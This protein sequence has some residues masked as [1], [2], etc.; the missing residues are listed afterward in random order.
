MLGL[1]FL[2]SLQAGSIG[3]YR[4]IKPYTFCNWKLFT[5][6]ALRTLKCNSL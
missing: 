5:N 6:F 4:K 2:L 3:R 1:T